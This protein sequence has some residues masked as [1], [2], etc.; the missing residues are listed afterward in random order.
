MFKDGRATVF[1]CGKVFRQVSRH[2][3]SLA[4]CE[5]EWTIDVYRASVIILPGG[6]L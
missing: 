6:L 3:L 5:R 1:A 4:S 2:A